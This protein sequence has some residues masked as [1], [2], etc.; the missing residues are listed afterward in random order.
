MLTS[1]HPSTPL[2]FL[3]SLGVRTP[4]RRWQKSPSLRLCFIWLEDRDEVKERGGRGGGGGVPA[5]WEAPAQ[6][7]KSSRTRGWELI[8]RRER[9]TL[10]AWL[11]LLRQGQYTL[12]NEDFEKQMVVSLV[13]PSSY[14]TLLNAIQNWSRSS[15]MGKCSKLFRGFFFFFSAS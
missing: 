3:S 6:P 1:L 7:D 14:F 10:F 12:W 11:K 5:F 8:K 4:H 15:P 13:L 2:L 9:S